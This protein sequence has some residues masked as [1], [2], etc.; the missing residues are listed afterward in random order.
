MPLNIRDPR[1]AELARKL[2]TR[3]ESTMTAVIIKA[4]ENEIRR[5]R[6]TVPLANRL[7]A[8]AVKARAQAGKHPQ[9][10]AKADRDALW[11]DA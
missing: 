6:D 5:E 10:V 2:A 11:G 9:L 4:L 7:A 3:R 1:A 8:L